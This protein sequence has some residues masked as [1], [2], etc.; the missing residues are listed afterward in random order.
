MIEK[1]RLL[2]VFL[3]TTDLAA[4][5]GE[6]QDL[7]PVQDSEGLQQNDKPFP[8][9]KRIRSVISPF[10]DTDQFAE[11]VLFLPEGIAIIAP[12]FFVFC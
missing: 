2:P 9:D 11:R 6:D 1:T 10:E 7:S 3:G 4:P 12:L 5:A 8:L